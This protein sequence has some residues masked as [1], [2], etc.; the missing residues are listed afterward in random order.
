VTP[1]DGS[2]YTTVPDGISDELIIEVKATWYVYASRQ[3]RVEIAL[4][5]P[6]RKTLSLVVQPQTAQT[7]VSRQLQG[8]IAQSGGTVRVR[9]GDNTYRNYDE[10]PG[11]AALYRADNG[12]WEKT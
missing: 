3:L 11:H 2:R 12:E 1:D 10:N 8:L 7:R 4:A 9:V 5:G 6:M